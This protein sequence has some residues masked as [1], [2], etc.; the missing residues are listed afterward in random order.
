M[1]SNDSS[2]NSE[3][4]RHPSFNNANL[5]ELLGEKPSIAELYLERDGR[6]FEVWLWGSR[7]TITKEQI[8]AVA[9]IADGLVQLDRKCLEA[10]ATG[11][12]DGSQPSVVDFGEH[13]SDVDVMSIET[14][15]EILG[16]QP[17][18]PENVIAKV[19]F[20]KVSIFADPAEELG[21]PEAQVA[22][23][24]YGLG[25]NVSQYILAISIDINGNIL[26]ID[27]ES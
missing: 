11:F 26:S 16:D 9:P 4:L 12:A 23:L 25:F 14:L 17:H 3:P 7:T 2:A 20:L 1:T 13:H 18:T 10:I 24:D 19:R 15:N 27:M 22:V 8:E 5:R 6:A 21:L